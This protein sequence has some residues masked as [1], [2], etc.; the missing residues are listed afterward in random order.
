MAS[1]HG[2]GVSLQSFL[3]FSRLMLRVVARCYTR[4]S[5]TIFLVYCTLPQFGC[6]SR[7]EIA[8]HP[9][10]LGDSKFLKMTS[11]WQGWV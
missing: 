10:M 11:L 8:R 7:V 1:C 5:A 2:L 3:L 6:F 9:L 4:H